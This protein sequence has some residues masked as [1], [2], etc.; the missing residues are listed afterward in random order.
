MQRLTFAIAILSLILGTTTLRADAILTSSGTDSYS[1]IYG[2]N[3]GPYGSSNTGSR[4]ID[5]VSYE[6][7]NDSA[8]VGV[9]PDPSNFSQLL[10]NLST[11]ADVVS[12]DPF[13]GLA[14]EPSTSFWG[15]FTLTAPVSYSLQFS[16][17]LG[18]VTTLSGIG[19]SAA[20]FLLY[21]V[22]TST[23]ILGVNDQYGW[24]FYAQSPPNSISQSGILAAGSYQIS[25]EVDGY[26]FTSYGDPDPGTATSTAALSFELDLGPAAAAPEPSTLTLMALA[27]ITFGGATWM[28]ARRCVAST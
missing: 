28:A 15:T 14:S 4:S 10:S 24:P 21:D 1:S 17:L 22:D 16:D 18:S 7:W 11:E 27:L 9:S 2:D 8:S 25:A 23:D 13:L 20:S 12:G 6:A 26:S 3:T 19:G 5:A